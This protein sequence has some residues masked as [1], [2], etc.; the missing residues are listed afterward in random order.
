MPA[1]T[2]LIVEDNPDNLSI[3][4]M[5]LEQLGWQIIPV[6]HP[7]DLQAAL[8]NPAGASPG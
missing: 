1:R 8:A 6:K 2:A 3:L 4:H 5:E 7:Q